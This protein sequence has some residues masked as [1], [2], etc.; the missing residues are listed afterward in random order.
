MKS[1]FI[2]LLCVF[3]Q[4]ILSAQN[5]I[6]LKFNP[7]GEFK[8]IQFTD[9]HVNI[10]KGQNLDI[11]EQFQKIIE[12]EKPDLVMVTG[13]VVAED[14]WKEAYPFFLELF[15]TEKLPWAVVFGNHDSKDSA[16]RED[17]AL[18][19][20]SLPFCLNVAND[21]GVTGSSNFVLPV[22]GD[23]EKAEALLYCLDSNSRSTL[24][25]RVDGYGWFDL[26]QIGWY[27]RNSKKYTMLNGGEPLPALAYF[28]IPLPEYDLAWNDKKAS[29]IGKKREPICCPDINTGMFAAMVQCGDVM[30]TFVGHDHYNDFVVNYYDIALAYGRASKIRNQKK[31][32]LGSRVV[33]LKEGKREFDSW[34]REGTGKK[35][36]ECTLPVSFK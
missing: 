3:P 6:K 1:I 25:P 4:F 10:Q 15:E 11:F 27:I 34:I 23:S 32:G 22:Y 13:D 18:F 24:Q 8:I 12:L 26:S 19:L 9:T 14:E 20:E 36:Q 21:G 35:L 5:K 16:S 17:I 29:K 33:V 7:N 31:P 28:H 2:L 30:G